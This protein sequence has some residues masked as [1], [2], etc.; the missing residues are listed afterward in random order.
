[1]LMSPDDGG[2]NDQVFEVRIIGHRIKNARPNTLDAPVF[3]D[4]IYQEYISPQH[5]IY[6]RSLAFRRPIS[7]HF[8]YLNGVLTSL[9]RLLLQNENY[10]EFLRLY[11]DTLGWMPENDVRN[12][13][14]ATECEI[15]ESEFFDV[16]HLREKTYTEEVL[17]TYADLAKKYAKTL[18]VVF[19]PVAC[20]FGSRHGS[21][22]TREA[23]ERFKSNHPEVEIPF[24]LI[25]TWPS[26]LFS[27]PAQHRTR[28]YG[29]ASSALGPGYR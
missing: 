20:T 27:V 7:D 10:L 3:G 1:M 28:A 22:K 9:D 4:A 19:Q 21:A 29:Y 15:E 11:Q 17:D 25:T 16:R 8:F 12:G 18:I 14:P 6:P 5:Y 2:I 13:V 26:E 24:P 23:I